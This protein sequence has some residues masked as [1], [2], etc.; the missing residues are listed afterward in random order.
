MGARSIRWLA[1]VVVSALVAAACGAAAAAPRPAVP[2]DADEQSVGAVVSAN[3]VLA[4]DLLRLAQEDSGGDNIVM[5]PH[6]ISTAMALVLG[7]ARDKTADELQVALAHTL[8]GAQL[9][10][11]VAALDDSLRARE[12]GT[13]RLSLANRVWLQDD[14]TVVPEFNAL[15]A[16][17]YDAGP[18]LVDFR[19]EPAAAIADVNNWGSEQTNGAVPQILGEIGKPKRLRWIVVNA[20]YFSGEWSDE[21]DPT[22]TMERS[23]TLVDA[24][25]V[26]VPT[27][28]GDFEVSTRSADGWRSARLPY[29]DGG[30]SMIVIVPRDLEE[31]IQALDA[32]TWSRVAFG[33][34]E[35]G[36]DRIEMPN[37]STRW[38]GDL[39]PM[40]EQMGVRDAFDCEADFSGIFD[41]DLPLDE[42]D[43]NIGFIQHEAFIEVDE[44]GTEAAAV[45]AVGGFQ[46]VS[47]SLPDEPPFIVDRPFVYA[48]T[49][50]L[51]GAILFIGAMSDP[52]IEASNEPPPPI[53]P[54]LCG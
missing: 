29:R 15:V 37:F 27:M 48:V 22:Q 17:V 21:F 26:Q 10:E 40:F 18:E 2:V 42:G 3:T 16:N 19:T 1:A 52:R 46:K 49:D 47:G 30:L 33:F 13:T 14:L 11:T 31:F 8:D 43:T 50:D 20:N 36:T 5:G 41:F 28:A 23:F 34:T 53:D 9:H 25:T 7:G 32:D 24:T 39:V 38:R 4:L 6:S 54:R 51:T 12:G 35:S 44:A 45:T